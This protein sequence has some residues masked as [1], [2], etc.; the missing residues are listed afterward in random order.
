MTGFS[1]GGH[2]TL[3]V[4]FEKITSSFF[5][6]YT[7]KYIYISDHFWMLK[8]SSLSPVKVFLIV[9]VSAR[10]F[11]ERLHTYIVLGISECQKFPRS[12]FV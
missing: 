10:V 1:L 3:L 5:F 9:S 11:H 4:S 7:C 12:V 8:V 2:G 6:F